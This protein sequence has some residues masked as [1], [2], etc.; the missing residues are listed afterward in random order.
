MRL[1]NCFTALAKVAPKIA[2][3]RSLE[4]GDRALRSDQRQECRALRRVI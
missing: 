3:L 4:P 1:F 2:S